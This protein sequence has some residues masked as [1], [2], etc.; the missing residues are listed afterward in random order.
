MLTISSIAIW[1]DNK[2]SMYLTYVGGIIWELKSRDSL[3][4]AVKRSA[5]RVQERKER[6]VAK[7]A[8]P[9]RKWKVA[10][11]KRKWKQKHGSSKCIYSITGRMTNLQ[12]RG[13]SEVAHK[14]VWAA[15]STR[16]TGWRRGG[17]RRGEEPLMERSPGYSSVVTLHWL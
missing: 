2:K 10:V 8:T 17:E 12:L 3:E 9:R 16:G 7:G 6:T 11:A 14:H 5:A 1:N 4:N 15:G 13:S